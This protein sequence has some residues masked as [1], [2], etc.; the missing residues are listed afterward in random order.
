MSINIDK[1]KLKDEIRHIDTFVSPFNA[2]QQSWSGYGTAFY[3]DV[4]SRWYDEMPVT[5]DLTHK[6]I[7][8]RRTPLYGTFTCTIKLEGAG[9]HTYL[10]PAF[11]EYWYN[12]HVDAGI[13]PCNLDGDYKLDTWNAGS[14]TRTNSI[15]TDWTAE[16]TQKIVWNSTN[17]YL[18]IDGVEKAHHTTNVPIKRMFPIEEIR[19]LASAPSAAA[20]TWC[21]PEHFDGGDYIA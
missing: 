5:T 3:D 12:N 13:L 17:V 1:T 7:C 9:T 10:Y 21:G 19:M 4:A 16:V 8:G 15:A 18:Y 20:K 14:Y 11:W 2:A 6:N